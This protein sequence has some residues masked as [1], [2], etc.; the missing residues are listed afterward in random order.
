MHN[1]C[2]KIFIVEVASLILLDKLT[3]KHKSH[4]SVNRTNNSRIE[5]D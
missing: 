1:D 5:I 2:Q 4:S 3:M